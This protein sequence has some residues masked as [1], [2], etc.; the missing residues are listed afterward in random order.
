MLFKD[1]L[2][3][4][5]EAGVEKDDNSIVEISLKLSMIYALL[6]RE[7]EAAQGYKF[8]I[9][10]MEKNLE[11]EPDDQNTAALLGLSIDSYARFLLLRHNYIE[12]LKQMERSLELAIKVFG[13]SHTQPLVIMND[14]ATV[15][16]MTKDYD[17]GMKYMKRAIKT[18]EKIKS[19]EMA[20]F[21]CNIGAIYLHKHQ[22]EEAQ[23]NC[24]HAAELAQK[25]GDKQSKLHAQSCLEQIKKITDK[26]N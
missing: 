4:L 2:K 21:Y 22:L 13:E 12:S 24:E 14:I 20:A 11:K 17:L 6:K 3:G 1:T 19:P 9:S 26:R 5:L 18:G 25:L 8:C 15:C 16:M 23:R 10:T 7:T